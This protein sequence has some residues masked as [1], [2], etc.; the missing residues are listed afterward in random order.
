MSLHVWHCSGA[1]LYIFIN[2]FWNIFFLDKGFQV[3]IRGEF[4]KH[5]EVIYDYYYYLYTFYDLVIVKKKANNRELYGK[6][7]F[8]KLKIKHS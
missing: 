1:Q 7:I 4:K 2:N 6:Y 8:L 3:S 5:N